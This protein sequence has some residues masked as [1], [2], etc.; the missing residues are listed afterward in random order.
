MKINNILVINQPVGNRGDESAHRALIK[1]LNEALPGAR[2]TVLAFQDFQ[3]AIGEF[4]VVNANNCYV[5]FLF[6]HNYMAYETAEFVTKHDIIKLGTELH[7]V[8]RKLKRYYKEADVVICA[9]GGICMGGFQNWRHLYL[10]QIAH[11]MH[12]PVVYYSRSIGPFPVS[13]PAERRF[14]KRSVELLRNFTFLSLRDRKSKELAGSMD[15][16]FTPS[17]DTAFLCQPHVELPEKIHS[18]LGTDYVVFV[19]NE[20]TWHFAFKTVPQDTIDSFYLFIMSELCDM[21]PQANIVML[22]Q[23]CS[24][25][26]KG[27]Y[28]Y[29][30]KLQQKLNNPKVVVLS[31]TYSSDVQQTVISRAQMVVG[32]RY[33]SVVFAI[34][35][36]I[37][38]VALSY[39]H[40][41]RGLLEDLSLTDNMVDITKGFDEA[42]AFFSKVLHDCKD[43][44]PDRQHAHDIAAD[45]FARMLNC[46]NKL[47]G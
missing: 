28:R 41:V 19:P 32:A 18:C 3:N 10:L 27:D 35:N 4:R 31:D 46:L 1:S 30:R 8:L 15:I 20:L 26:E 45:C 2:I 12:K 29:F 43:R 38:F 16:P 44:K 7:P 36:E 24:L 17:V 42:K 6:R 40:K 34:N 37:P 33:H 11:W 25:G 39:E 22:P 13:T 23:L 21:Y 9:P 47:K 14:R 5:N